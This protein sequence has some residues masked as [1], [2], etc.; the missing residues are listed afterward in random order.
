M[1]PIQDVL[2]RISVAIRRGKGRFAFG[3]SSDT[4]APFA[5]AVGAG[6]AV[7]IGGGYVCVVGMT[8][9]HVRELRDLLSEALGESGA[10]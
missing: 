6:N 1:R 2:F 3:S 5:L 7:R 4:S 9:Q 10:S 8:V